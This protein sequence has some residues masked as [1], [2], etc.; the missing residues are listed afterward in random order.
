MGNNVMAAENSAQNSLF[1]HLS[2]K[3]VFHQLSLSLRKE[4][5][6][7]PHAFCGIVLA[8]NIVLSL[9]ISLQLGVS[10]NGIFASPILMY[11]FM[12]FLTKT[13]QAIFHYRFLVE[14]T[15]ETQKTVTN[16]LPVVENSF[17]KCVIVL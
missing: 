6:K 16:I 5:I 13:L 12:V 17:K 1:M 4:L 9:N 15:I 8:D 7:N 11:S 2:C 3:N 14:K 10:P